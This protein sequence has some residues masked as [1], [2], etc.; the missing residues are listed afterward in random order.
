MKNKRQVA[1]ETTRIMQTGSAIGLTRL[2]FIAYTFSSSKEFV[3]WR[4]LC[5]YFYLH[6]VLFLTTPIYPH[7]KILFYPHWLLLV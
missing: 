3:D 7:K 6:V 2:V 5:G 4:F 1:D